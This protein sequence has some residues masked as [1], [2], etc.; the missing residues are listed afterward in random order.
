MMI[1]LTKRYTMVEYLRYINEFAGA[2]T[3]IIICNSIKKRIMFK[4]V[5]KVD[6]GPPGTKRFV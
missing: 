1:A 6:D 2:S 4:I 5:F 3:S